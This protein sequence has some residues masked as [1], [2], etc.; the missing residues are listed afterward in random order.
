[1]YRYVQLLIQEMTIK[2]E[3][4]FLL[5]LLAVLKHEQADD[6]A[7]FDLTL[8]KFQKDMD[9]TKLSIMSEARQS[10]LL[11]QEHLY[12]YI[13]LSPIKVFTYA[14]SFVLEYTQLVLSVV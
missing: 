5:S 8:Q 14:L 13:H 10:R 3:V 4:G 1:M 9:S 12:D 11:M 2:L 6:N 7:D